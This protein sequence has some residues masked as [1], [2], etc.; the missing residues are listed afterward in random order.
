MRIKKS[1]HA[2][3]LYRYGGFD[4]ASNRTFEVKIGS[5]SVETVPVIGTDLDPSLVDNNIPIELWE[6]LTV[7]EQRTLIDYLRLQRDQRLRSRLTTLSDDLQLFAGQIRPDLVDRTLADGLHDGLTMLLASLK[8]AGYVN[9][10]QKRTPRGQR[11]SARP[12]TDCRPEAIAA[13]I[14]N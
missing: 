11:L 3:Y 1:G 2:I 6:A 8:K 7:I 4:K 5:L 10:R 12:S 14:S 9:P 13:S